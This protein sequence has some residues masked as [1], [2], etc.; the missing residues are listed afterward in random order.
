MSVTF[1]TTLFQADGKNATGIEV[2]ADA[3][4]ALG[5]QKRPRVKVAL[6]DFTYT[7]TV[8]VYG[9]TF[10][11]PVSAERREAAGLKAG[12]SVNVT[13]EL[14]TA[15]Q[16]L[17]IPADLSAALAAKT[18]AQEAFDATAFSKRKEFVRQVNEAKAAETR[19]KRIAKIVEGLG[20]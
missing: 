3:I 17:D 14:D 18:G 7:T 19:A 9:D 8:G 12:D 11:I 5:S 20:S 4:A 6:N 15:P 16:T 2:P 13:L 1:T 10:L